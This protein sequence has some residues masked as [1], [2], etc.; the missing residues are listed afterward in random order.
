MDWYYA[1]DNQPVGPVSDHQLQA[2][3]AGDAFTAETL[4]WREGWPAWRRYADVFPDPAA[5]S[6]WYYELHGQPVGPL[7]AKEFQRLIADRKI[8]MDT[9]VWREGL[10]DW[11]PCREAIR[12]PAPL[13]APTP[14]TA[15]TALT[16]AGLG[17]R[18]F[19]KLIDWG[20]VLVGFPILI[21]LGPGLLHDLIRDLF[22]YSPHHHWSGREFFIIGRIAATAYDTC[23]LGR[24][25]GTVGK[26]VCGIRVV[27]LTGERISYGRA[28]KRHLAEYLSWLLLFSGY[29][30][31]Q[32]NDLRQTLHD[33]LAGTRV[34]NA[35]RR[36]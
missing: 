18:A 27:T 22:P 24:F 35:P 13:I 32:F 26:L 23:L 29:L 11:R 21:V 31:A 1:A 17:T 15:P 25:G 4:V 33:D 9:L 19:A 8:W 5:D 12:V 20:L 28:L 2:L 3:R 10:T 16:V 14:P 30:S 34:V 36:P 6:L 7:T